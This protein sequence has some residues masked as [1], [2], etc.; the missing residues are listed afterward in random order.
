[1]MRL[2]CSPSITD[3]DANAIESGYAQRDEV[4]SKAVTK[5]I[6]DMLSDPDLASQTR[7]LATLVKTHALDIRLALRKDGAGIYHEKIGVF[8]DAF[9]QR[10]SFLGSANETWSAWHIQGNHESVEVFRENGGRNDA[11]RVA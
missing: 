9:G 2:V 8:A 4:V 3:D 11:R 1:K 7:V 6:E 5:D 10:V